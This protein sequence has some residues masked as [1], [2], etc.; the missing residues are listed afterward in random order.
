M[1]CQ[2][3][4][5]NASRA[6]FVHQSIKSFILPVETTA[7]ILHAVQDATAHCRLHMLNLTMACS[8]H[9]GSAMQ[10]VGYNPEQ[11]ALLLSLP[12]AKLPCKNL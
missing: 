11:T 5:P 2:S 8:H 7:T 3:L 10:R 9:C 12:G 1:S 6:F 4:I